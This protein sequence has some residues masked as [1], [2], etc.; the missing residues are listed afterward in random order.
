M[1][2]IFTDFR[3]GFVTVNRSLSID[4]LPALCPKDNLSALDRQFINLKVTSPIVSKFHALVFVYG[5]LYAFPPVYQRHLGPPL[6]VLLV[7][8][9]TSVHKFREYLLFAN[10][11]KI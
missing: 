1:D 4:K 10:D 6:F 7:N 5:L 2:K 3:R 11:V 9:L 8:D